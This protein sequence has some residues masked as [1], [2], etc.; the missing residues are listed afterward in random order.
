MSP[1]TF[2]DFCL[3][4]LYQQII[5]HTATTR[6][7]G[8]HGGRVTKKKKT[9]GGRK[10]ERKTNMMKELK[11][12]VNNTG[13]AG[14]RLKVMNTSV[15]FLHC[16]LMTTLRD[17]TLQVVLIFRTLTSQLSCTLHILNGDVRRAPAS[18]QET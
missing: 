1:A 9:R 17:D 3:T 11:R 13:N 12:K 7:T 2:R 6:N 15:C 5:N 10:T 8:A 4:L 18:Q 16:R 14:C